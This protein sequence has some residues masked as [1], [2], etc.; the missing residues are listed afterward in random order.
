MSTTYTVWFW[1]L[2][3]ETLAGVSQICDLYCQKTLFK[4]VYNWVVRLVRKHDYSTYHWHFFHSNWLLFNRANI[5]IQEKVVAWMLDQRTWLDSFDF[6]HLIWSSRSM[7]IIT[8]WLFVW[9][10]PNAMFRVI[11]CSSLLALIKVLSLSLPFKITSES[12]FL[13]TM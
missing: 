12:A 10:Q 5:Q 2:N 1:Q 11:F 9:I 6:I 4:T 7:A 13:H 3:P 8:H